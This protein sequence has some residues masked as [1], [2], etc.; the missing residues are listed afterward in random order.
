MGRIRPVVTLGNRPTVISVRATPGGN[1]SIHF[2]GSRSS[3][4]MSVDVDGAMRL[5]FAIADAVETARTAP[6]VI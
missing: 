2:S 1:V 4:E 5:G 3:D 6:K